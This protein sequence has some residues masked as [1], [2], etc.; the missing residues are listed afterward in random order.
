M[1][2]DGTLLCLWQ[3]QLPLQAFPCLL[4]FFA[5]TITTSLK[6]FRINAYSNQQDDV[7]Y[8]YLQYTVHHNNFAFFYPFPKCTE[9]ETMTKRSYD[10]KLR[11][12]NL[13]SLI[14]DLIPIL[15]WQYIYPGHCILYLV[16]NSWLHAVFQKQPLS[17]C[18]D[19]IAMPDNTDSVPF[20]DTL[21]LWHTSFQ[22]LVRLF[23][24]DTQFMEI[25]RACV[26]NVYQQGS[27]YL[28]SILCDSLVRYTCTNALL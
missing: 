13:Q 9:C 4:T 27:I 22:I 2:D 23:V 14:C 18:F 28:L 24:H 5:S 8:T 12:I 1:W 25:L 11:F 3:W 10:S 7:L 17:S 16:L 15:R 6:Q 19:S 20:Q 26:N 21:I